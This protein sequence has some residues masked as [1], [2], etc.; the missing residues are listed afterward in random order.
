M[1]TVTLPLDLFEE[2][3]DAA[4]APEANPTVARIADDVARAGGF[5]ALAVDRRGRQRRRL[6]RVQGRGRV[7]SG[8]LCLV[9]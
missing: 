6:V 4:A 2:L 8:A 9:V 1:Q 7:K 3:R 5:T